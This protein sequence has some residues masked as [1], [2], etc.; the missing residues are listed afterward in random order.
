MRFGFAFCNALLLAL[1]L[2]GRGHAADIEQWGMWELSLDGP[3]GQSVPRRGTVRY[4][5]PSAFRNVGWSLANEFDFMSNLDGK[6]PG[7]MGTDIGP[8]A[9]G[10]FNPT[11]RRYGLD[12]QFRGEIRGLQ[13]F[14]SRVSGRER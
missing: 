8:L 2:V 6:H 11:M 4:V 13:L 14:G 10:N 3:R 9:I 1:I 12:R 7:P 5:S